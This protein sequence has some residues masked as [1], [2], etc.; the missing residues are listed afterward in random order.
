MNTTL[1]SQSPPPVYSPSLINQS[2]NHLDDDRLLQLWLG[3]FDLKSQATARHYRTQS[4]KFRLFLQLLHPDWARGTHLQ[5]ASEQD[6]AMYEMALLLKPMPGGAQLDL[7]LPE[8][9]LQLLGLDHQPFDAALKKSSVNQAL[10]VLNALYE[11]LRTPNGVMRTPYVNVNPVKRVRKSVTRSIRQTDRHIPLNGVKAMSEYLLV[12]IARANAENDQA[13]V[14]G[15]E[16]KLW[17]FTLLF[18]LWGR[19]EEVCTLSMGDFRQQHDESWKVSLLRKGG[20]EQEVP[21]ADWVIQGLRRYRGSLGL[22]KT[23]LADDPLPAIQ[24]L[25]VVSP[26]AVSTTR[27]SKAS[28]ARRT[29]KEAPIKHVNPQTLYL[30]IRSLATQTADEIVR[31]ALLSELSLQRRTMLSERLARCSPHWF[32]HSGPTIAINSGAI[33]VENASKMLGHSSLATTTQMYYHAD[34][35]KMRAG[36]DSLGEHL[37]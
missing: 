22:P 4:N 32:R 26:K 8:R 29:I 12:A 35:E 17:I 10:S 14:L 9:E 1:S 19:R 21:A 24:S 34:D 37:K 13:A 3:I 7:R 30:E 28:N 25:R 20:K 36:L 15:Y 11:F 2:E 31:G 18:G 6:V 23:W 33:S 27:A 5:Q 16:R